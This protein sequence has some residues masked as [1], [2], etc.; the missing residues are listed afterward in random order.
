MHDTQEIIEVLEY[1][2]KQTENIIEQEIKG[3]NRFL[4]T[5]LK[6]EELDG[7][8]ANVQILAEAANTKDE[9]KQIIIDWG[10]DLQTVTPDQVQIYDLEE[11]RK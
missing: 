2:A 8:Y 10:Y 7:G 4:V 5:T 6:I 9:M 1:L 11:L 3:T